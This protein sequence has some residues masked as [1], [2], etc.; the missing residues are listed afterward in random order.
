VK[1]DQLCADKSAKV[2]G[3]WNDCKGQTDQTN[4]DE[5]NVPRDAMIG[6]QVAGR[7]R[8]IRGAD[9]ELPRNTLREAPARDSIN[10]GHTDTDV[11]GAQ[12]VT[13]DGGELANQPPERTTVFSCHAR[14][15]VAAPQRHNRV[16]VGMIWFRRRRLVR[17]RSSLMGRATAGFA[18]G[19]TPQAL[20]PASGRWLL[21]SRHSTEGWAVVLLL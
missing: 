3:G 5:R 9:I 12:K 17:Q 2:A 6:L 14:L 20:R 1:G 16:V 19:F 4:Q 11:P 13:S 21:P 8:R 18:V 7:Y 15:R 10:T